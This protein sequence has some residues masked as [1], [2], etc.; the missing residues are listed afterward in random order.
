MSKEIGTENDRVLTEEEFEREMIDRLSAA[1]LRKVDA[2]M[3][4]HDFRQKRNALIMQGR[5]APP[6]PKETND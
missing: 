4:A 5:W 1:I 6:L 3:A 2:K